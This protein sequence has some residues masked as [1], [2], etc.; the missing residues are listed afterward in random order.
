M[1]AVD[2]S[3]FAAPVSPK[4]LIRIVTE[5]TGDKAGALYKAGV[6]ETHNNK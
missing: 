5:S 4:V 3:S 1:T 6:F 2:L